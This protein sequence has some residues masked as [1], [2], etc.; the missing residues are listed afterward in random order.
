MCEAGREVGS[1]DVGGREGCTPRQCLRPGGRQVGPDD[2]CSQREARPR[3]VCVRGDA[4]HKELD[5]L[6]GL[7]IQVAGAKNHKS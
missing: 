3:N 7:S 2:V 4:Q 6:L 1:G 5:L